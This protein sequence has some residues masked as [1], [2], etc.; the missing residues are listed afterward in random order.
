MLEGVWPDAIIEVDPSG[1]IVWEFHVK[2]HIGTAK[3]QWD[4]NYHLPF[5]YMPAY[6]AG[7]DWTHW[8]SVRYN[9]KTDQYLV[10][11]RDWGEMYIIDRKTKKMVWRWANPY[12][13]ARAPRNRATPA[14]ATRF[15]SAPTTAT[16]C[17]TAT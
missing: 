14:T 12:A 13:T 3:D 5:G 4:P 16:G 17:P 11:S 9:P 7:P 6:F 15:F 1:K 10:N 8:N 2:D